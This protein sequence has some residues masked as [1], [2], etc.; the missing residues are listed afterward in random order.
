[1]ANVSKFGLWRHLRAEPNQFILHY[2]GGKLVKSGA[3]IA[4]FFNPLSAAVAQVPV[5]DCET[6][7]MLN[8]RSADFQE[9]NVQC[10]LSYRVTDH[11]R[12]A[13]RV[14]FTISLLT[15]AWLEQPLDRLATLWSQKALEPVRKFVSASPV[16]D[17]AQKGSEHIRAAL[18]SALRNDAELAAMGLALV[19][20]QVSRVAP[21]AE[22]EKAL[23]TPTREG[24]QQKADEAMFSRRALA[25][26]K[27]RAIKENELATE[28]ELEKRKKQLIEQRGANQLQEVQQVATTEKARVEADLARLQLTAEA[29]T[30][31]SMTLAKTEV[32]KSKLIA[33]ALRARHAAARRGRHEGAHAVEPDRAAARGRAH[34]ALGED[35]AARVHGLRAAGRRR[36]ARQDQPPQPD[37]GPLEDA[38]D[39]ARHGA[40][41]DLVRW[42]NASRASWWSLARRR[43]SCCWSGTARTG[44]PSSI[45]PR[46]GSP[47]SRS[48][49]STRA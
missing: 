8:E 32:E 37:A 45:C 35:P 9:V 27:E 3:G 29:E 4:Y 40:Q 13:Q 6:T 10:T 23:Q 34:R 47:S 14:N 24:L 49:A 39:G 48:S 19:T 11:A 20:V 28:L 43:S 42:R 25:V 12:A 26:E 31:R 5:E 41:R 16:V 22:L 2:K 1:M 36:E 7:F 18:D 15:G 46:V 44:R 33:D 38:G 21:S 17:V 30:R